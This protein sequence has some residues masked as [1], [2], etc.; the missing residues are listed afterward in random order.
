MRDMKSLKGT[1]LGHARLCQAALQTAL[2]QLRTWQLKGVRGPF[3]SGYLLPPPVIVTPRWPV[4][5]DEAVIHMARQMTASCAILKDMSQRVSRQAVAETWL[6]I[7][8]GLHGTCI[9]QALIGVV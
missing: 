5:R 8:V 9:Q 7:A 6:Q 3:I 2:A 4:R 1:R